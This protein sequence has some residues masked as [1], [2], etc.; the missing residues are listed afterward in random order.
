MFAFLS[1]VWQ[2]LYMANQTDTGLHISM[3]LLLG[4]V[5]GLLISDMLKAAVKTVDAVQDS[6]M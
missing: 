1:Y 3:R 2:D 5:A 4:I 6:I